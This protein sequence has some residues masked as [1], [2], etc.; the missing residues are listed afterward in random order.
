MK[1]KHARDPDVLLFSTAWPRRAL[2]R[3]QLI[4]DGFEVIAVDTWAD[5]RQ[6]FLHG[7]RPRAAI[8]DLDG[9]GEAASVLRECET[10]ME[11]DRVLVVTAAGAVAPGEIERHG[12]R[13][14]ARPIDVSTIV[15]A[16]SRAL[17]R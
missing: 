7:V 15:A 6:W 3:A 9:V 10:L 16:V 14:L 8:V 4:E 1:R 12:F 5:A 13:V 2:L 11:H 17:R